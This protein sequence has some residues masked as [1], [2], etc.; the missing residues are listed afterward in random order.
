MPGEQE[1]P[2]RIIRQYSECDGP[3]DWQQQPRAKGL[4]E[5]S[6]VFHPYYLRSKTAGIH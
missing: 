2:N 1:N 4:S 6:D 3:K 5:M